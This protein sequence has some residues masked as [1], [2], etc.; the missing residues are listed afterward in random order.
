M[1]DDSAAPVMRLVTPLGHDY[2]RDSAGRVYYSHLTDDRLN[3]I[4]GHNL[5]PGVDLASFEVLNRNWA[6]DAKHV[7]VLSSRLRADR[8]SFEV[9]NT[10]YARDRDWVFYLGGK[11]KD[12][13]R[14][15]FEVLDSGEQ[16]D[17]PCTAV[18]HLTGAVSR[19]DFFGYARDRSRVYFHEMLIGKPRAI[20][21]ADRETFEV[22]TGEFARDKD[23]VFLRETRVRAADRATF[24]SLGGGFYRDHRHVFYDTEIIAGADRESFVVVDPYKHYARDRHSLYSCGMVLRPAEFLNRS[25]PPGE[26]SEPD[27]E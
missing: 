4:R 21:F 24:E 10:L 18:D 2:W 15:S 26:R 19:V 22:V 3:V 13:H 27:E 25:R 14:D 8:D 17:G 7:Y 5:I 11:A 23:W 1:T 16:P 9:L 12:I 6:R 20:R